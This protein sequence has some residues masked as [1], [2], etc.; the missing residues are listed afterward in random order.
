MN[1]F[2]AID[3]KISNSGTK[4]CHRFGIKKKNV[5]VQFTNRKHCSFALHNRKKLMSFDNK[6]KNLPNSGFF[7]SENSTPMNS[8]LAFICWELRDGFFKTRRPWMVLCTYLGLDWKKKAMKIFHEAKL[9]NFFPEHDFSRFSS[10]L[11]ENA[12]SNESVQSSYWWL[13]YEFFSVFWS[14][15]SL[16]VRLVSSDRFISFSKILTKTLRKACSFIFFRV[17]AHF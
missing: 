16:K 4:A 14:K 2:N 10:R 11:K 17:D 6:E 13:L 7:I 8:K 9:H 3:A 1:I 5:I 15:Y 12:T